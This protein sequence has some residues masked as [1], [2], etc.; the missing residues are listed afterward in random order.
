MLTSKYV[1]DKLKYAETHLRSISKVISWRILLTTSHVINGF[2]VSGS[3]L[4]GLQ[5][6]ALATIINSFIFWAHERS[7]NFVQWNR[8]PNDNI[9]FHEGQ[10]RTISKSVT[11]RILI[12]ISNFVIPFI[13]TGSW[14]SAAA[15]LGI[16]TLVNIAIF[17]GHE[18]VWNRISW[19]KINN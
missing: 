16:A 12:T 11:W 6:A 10:P 8:K 1:M 13:M 19:G 5:I 14:G 9:L 18:R 4:T 3:W 17:Y 15:F 2:I 7:W